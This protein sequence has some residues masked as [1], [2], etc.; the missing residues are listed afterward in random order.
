M[1]VPSALTSWP[2]G[3]P[4]RASINNFG[5]GGTNA[6]IILEAPPRLSHVLPKS[7]NGMANGLSHRELNASPDKITNGVADGRTNGTTALATNGTTA[8]ISNGVTKEKFSRGTDVEMTGSSNAEVTNGMPSSAGPP[9]NG[10]TIAPEKDRSLVYILSAKDSTAV[11][12][13]GRNLA[14]HICESTELGTGP[15]PTDLAYTLAERRSRFHWTTAL[16]ANN[17]AEL[18][19]RLAEPDRKPSRATKTPRLGFVFNGQGAQWHAMAR[20][21][22]D[23]YPVFRRSLC[24]AERI[25]KDYGASWSL[26]GAFCQNHSD[27]VF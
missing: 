4:R 25:L 3:K 11:Q 20:E 1:Q 22:I 9:P 14:E 7:L 6:H 10:T 21:L 27:L 15:S 8:I 23:G 19:D 24:A 13:M 26:Q 12:Q 17:V 5:Y 18:A 16:R 2:A